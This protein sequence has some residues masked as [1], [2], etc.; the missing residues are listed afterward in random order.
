MSAT[1]TRS[2]LA[3]SDRRRS[4]PSRRHR[5]ARLATCAATAAATLPLALTSSGASAADVGTAETRCDHVDYGGATYVECEVLSS[6]RIDPDALTVDGQTKAYMPPG[7]PIVVTA[8]GGKGE[9]G[10]FP[11][12]FGEPGD[13]GVARTVVTPDDVDGMYAY[14]G[15][16]GNLYSNRGGSSSALTAMP[17]DD[18]TS[19]GDVHVIAGGGGS[20]GSV[21]TCHFNGRAGGGSGGAGGVA[22]ATLTH[23]AAAYGAGGLSTHGEVKQ[24]CAYPYEGY[25]PTAGNRGIGGTSPDTERANGNDGFGGHGGGGNHWV[26]NPSTEHTGGAGGFDPDHHQVGGGGGYGGGAGG[27][28]GWGGSGGGSFGAPVPA[29][30]VE[31]VDQ[32]LALPDPGTG[33]SITLAWPASWDAGMVS[34]DLQFAGA[35]ELYIDGAHGATYAANTLVPMP[36]GVHEF[37]LTANPDD[38]P[39]NGVA[40]LAVPHAPGTVVFGGEAAGNGT[41]LVQ[42][43]PKRHVD[44][45]IGIDFASGYDVIT[46]GTSVATYLHG[47]QPATSASG[48]VSIDGVAGT[49]GTPLTASSEVW[50][51]YGTDTYE[52][53]V[54]SLDVAIQPDCTVSG[55]ATGELLRD[56]GS[57]Q[58]HQLGAVSGWCDL[59]EGTMTLNIAADGLPNE[60]MIK[61]R[62]V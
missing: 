57:P 52:L 6:G 46:D 26:S 41:Q 53:R 16:S 20:K 7:V 19:E 58:S 2:D 50:L 55:T 15:R 47:S 5:V 61:L 37:T 12:V 33:R 40:L 13:G 30:Y 39:S 43:D 18:V 9:K 62:E 35:V 24:N 44:I 22:D 34:L 32:G 42:L 38:I 48:H 4:R 14:L 49:V 29:Q 8:V 54:D 17:I 10:D 11:G 45:V 25:Q 28:R 23:G 60:S 31:W 51:P 59:M 1:L 3:V 56:E 27:A 21:N 36:A